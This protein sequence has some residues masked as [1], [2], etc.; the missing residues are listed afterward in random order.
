MSGWISPRLGVRF[1]RSGTELQLYRPDGERFAT[2]L[3]LMDMKEQETQARQR[4]EQERDAIAQAQREA[5][6]R[7]LGMG[8]TAEQVAQAL[9]LSL[10]LVQQFVDGE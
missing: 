8:L 4:A 6:R 10:A 3:E 1:Q 9:S 7:L 5:I 2:Y